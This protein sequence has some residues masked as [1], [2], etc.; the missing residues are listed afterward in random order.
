MRKWHIKKKGGRGKE[1]LRKA[2][3]ELGSGLPETSVFSCLIYSASG[4]LL[5]VFMIVILHDPV[6]WVV[7]TE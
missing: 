6:S 4:N 2:G 5:P 3:R 7:C 1:S